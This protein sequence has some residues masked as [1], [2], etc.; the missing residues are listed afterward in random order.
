MRLQASN[1]FKVSPTLKIECASSR[2]HVF[3]KPFHKKNNEE[4]VV[5]CSNVACGGSIRRLY[6]A[7]RANQLAK[8]RLHRVIQEI[9]YS[10]QP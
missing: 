2:Q 10:L 8:Q 7:H 9:L 6:K 1:P 4:L 5:V 3:R